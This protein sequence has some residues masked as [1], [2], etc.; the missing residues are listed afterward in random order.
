MA[1][2]NRLIY[3]NAWSAFEFGSVLNE[4]NI[5]QGIVHPKINIL[6]SFTYPHVVPNLYEF[7]SN[8]EQKK[9]FKKMLKKQTVAGS[10]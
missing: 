5:L 2:F 4:Q 10:H 9:I 1:T 8:V 7:L 6:S 3:D